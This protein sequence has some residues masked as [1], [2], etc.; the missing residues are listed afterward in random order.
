MDSIES[1]ITRVAAIAELER[2]DITTATAKKITQ[3]PHCRRGCSMGDSITF[4][5]EESR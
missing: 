2:L 4:T 3:P 5:M 1:R